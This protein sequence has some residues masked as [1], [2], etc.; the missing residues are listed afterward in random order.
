MLS[1][2]KPNSENKRDLY[3]IANGRSPVGQKVH[4]FG[5]QKRK[6]AGDRAV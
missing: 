1:I 6:L 4:K 3:R 2:K 5:A